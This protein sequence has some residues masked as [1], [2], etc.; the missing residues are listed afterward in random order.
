MAFNV[1]TEGM[2]RTIRERTACANAI[3]HTDP[4]IRDGDRYEPVCPELV[5]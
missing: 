2:P 3:G 4:A 1:M 5:P